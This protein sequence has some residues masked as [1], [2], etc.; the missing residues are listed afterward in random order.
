MYFS[1]ESKNYICLVLY[2]DMERIYKILELKIDVSYIYG[3]LRNY[4]LG[5]PLNKEWVLETG[6]VC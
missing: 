1:N 3:F 5:V 4:V 6:T 2:M